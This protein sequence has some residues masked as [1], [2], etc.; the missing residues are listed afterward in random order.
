MEKQIAFSQTI[1]WNGGCNCVS[2]SGYASPN[3]ALRAAIE[4]AKECGWTPPRWWQFWRWGDL[5][6]NEMLNVTS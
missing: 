3:L 6:Y 5:D 1:E 4:A 2:V